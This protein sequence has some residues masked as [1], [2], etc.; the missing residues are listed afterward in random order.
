[1]CNLPSGILVPSISMAL[2]TLNN[3]KFSAN[4]EWHDI[5]QNLLYFVCCRFAES[6]CWRCRILSQSELNNLSLEYLHSVLFLEIP[7]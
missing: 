6:S 5:K 3:N 2:R 1:M 7:P 4:L